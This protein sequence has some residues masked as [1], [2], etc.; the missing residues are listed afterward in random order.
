MQ[1]LL[2]QLQVWIVDGHR[3]VYK[4]SFVFFF[5]GWYILVKRNYTNF[6]IYTR[7][8]DVCV[9]ACGWIVEIRPNGKYTIHISHVCFLNTSNWNESK[10][11]KSGC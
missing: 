8:W 7:D 10:C 11:N 4:L 2:P 5:Y 1:L 6:P 9:Y 3:M